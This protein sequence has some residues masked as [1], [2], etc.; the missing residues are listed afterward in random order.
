MSVPSP[1]RRSNCRDAGS[2]AQP[3][4]WP[5]VVATIRR[6]PAPRSA[7]AIRP[8]GAAAPNHTEA[9]S[10]SRSSRTAWRVTRGVGSSIVVRSRTTVNGCSA[11]KAAVASAPSAPRFQVE[12]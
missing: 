10:C 12:A 9:Q 4:S 2:W 7:G 8:R 6:A 3:A 1:I 11:S 5:C